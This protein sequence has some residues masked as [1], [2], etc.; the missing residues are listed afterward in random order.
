MVYL[1]LE[2]GKCYWGKCYF[3]GWGKRESQTDIEELKQRFEKVLKHS[4]TKDIVKIFSS[5][6]FLD[7]NQFPVDFVK[8]C[9]SKAKEYG[10]DEIVIESRAEFVKEDI[11]KEIKIPGIRI[12]VALG[13][14][15]ANDEVLRL[16][17]K[18]LSVSD[19]E[20]ACK[21]LK[22]MGFGIRLYIL[23]N[24]HPR[25]YQDPKLQEK[26]LLDS[27]DFA[28]KHMDSAVIINAYPHKNSRL[29][30]DWI[31]GRWHPLTKK[32]FYALLNKVFS[33]YGAKISEGEKKIELN[34]KVFE[35][36]FENFYF[37]PKIPKEKRE[38][39]K[40]VGRNV[41]LHPHFNVWQEYL[42]KFYEPPKNKKYVLFLPCSYGKPYKK[43]K[44]HK[45]IIRTISGYPWFKYLHLIVVS[46]P[47][48]V[49]WE[50]Q[51]KYPFWSYDW[52]EWEE[53]D[54]VK[55]DYIEITKDR[56]K[57][58]VE[59]HKGHYEK[60]FLYFHKDSETKIAIV[61]AFKEL[62]LE[63]LLID[64]LNDKDFEFLEPGKRIG[65]SVLRK[66]EMLEKLKE[67]L[68]QVMKKKIK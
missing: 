24:G 28:L 58:F 6:S 61:Q 57:K 30:D 45:R 47:G 34:G 7:K 21:L 42:Q 40:G 65:S 1:T 39:I 48:V 25:L 31:E 22:R 54:E 12:T 27:V 46:T 2:H 9:I 13:L 14:E 66:E 5:G 60:Y 36:D 23:V 53:T 63:H 38:F 10:F 56:V 55:K 62:S 16:Y 17:N 20:R 51:T 3:C 18:G 4:K 44:T 59:A 43:S 33:K 35:I 37:I 50:L 52:P 29:L 26:A 49:P 41:L 15:S 19:Y 68:N 67:R 11:L 32:E 64:L 8:F